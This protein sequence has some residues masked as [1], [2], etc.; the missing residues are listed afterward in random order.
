MIRAAKAWVLLLGGWK[1][2][3]A[4]EC[5]LSLVGAAVPQHLLI[6]AMRGKQASEFARGSGFQRKPEFHTLVSHLSVFI[7][8]SIF[9]T[10]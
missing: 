9:R 4:A 8:D 3:A 5:P 6:V 2:A 7:L 10:L 1:P